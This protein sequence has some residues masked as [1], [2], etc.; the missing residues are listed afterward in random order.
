MLPQAGRGR[1]R[2]SDVY[3]LEGGG[4]GIALKGRTFKSKPGDRTNINQFIRAKEVRVIDPEGKQVGVVSIDAALKSAAEFGLDLVEI[5]P[6]ANPP[7]CKIM[8]YGRYKYEQ[9][10]KKQ[11]AKK[12]QTTF[13]L[14]EIK[15]RPNTDDHDLQVKIGYIKKFID[16]KDK[17]KVT[18]MFRGR[19]ITLSQLGRDMLA[20]IAEETADVAVVEQ[21]PK[22]EGRTLMMVL[23]PR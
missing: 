21:Y 6:N 5:S 14:K 12:K 15:V 9:T 20:K 22:F 13:Q 10:K 7:V 23:S 18:V 4:A 2:R 1:R 8:D 11:E 17:V 3:L 16:K 19:E